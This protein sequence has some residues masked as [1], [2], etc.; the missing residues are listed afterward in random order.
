MSRGT[1][2]RS[3]VSFWASSSQL[4][5]RVLNSDAGPVC[6]LRGR[7][8]WRCSYQYALSEPDRGPIRLID[9]FRCPC[10]LLP[11]EPHWLMSGSHRYFHIDTS[12]DD[13]APG[14]AVLTGSGKW[15]VSKCW[16]DVFTHNGHNE[17]YRY[18]WRQAG[19]QVEEEVVEVR[20]GVS[21]ILQG[22]QQQQTTTTTTTC[23]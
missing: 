11:E 8:R 23:Y 18:T 13:G 9:D 15:Y 20:D 2:L 1:Y 5:R 21:I 16:A 4:R 6:A 22:Q 17:G 12:I 3:T 7:Y 19:R 10:P 14:T